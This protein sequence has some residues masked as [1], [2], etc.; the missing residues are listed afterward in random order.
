MSV[1][2]LGSQMC[3]CLC[4]LM[5]FRVVWSRAYTPPMMLVAFVLCIISTLQTVAIGKTGVDL[6]TPKKEE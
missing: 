2:S 6:V 3:S 5:I 1:E 4:V